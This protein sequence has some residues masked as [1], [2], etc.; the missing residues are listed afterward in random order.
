MY[1]L[2]LSNVNQFTKLF[3]CH[4]EKIGNNTITKNPTTP[5]TCCYTTQLNATEWGKLPQRLIHHVQG[6]SDGGISVYIPPPKKKKNQSTL[7]IFIWLLVVLF[8]CGTLTC[9]ILKL[10]W[11]VKIYT[12]QMK[13]LATPL[14]TSLLLVSGV[15]GLN[16]SSSSKSDTLQILCKNCR[17][18]QLLSTITETLN[19]L[20]PVANF[21]KCDATEVVVLFSICF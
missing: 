6:R 12:P 13:F 4:Q 7:P 16:A 15:A 18:W 10:E 3:H 14:I 9:L 20:F 1:A 11:L 17:M 8:T 21:L 5:K 19:T 2:T